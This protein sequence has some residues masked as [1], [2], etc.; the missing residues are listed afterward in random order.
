MKR[1]EV[2]QAELLAPAGLRPVVIPTRDAVLDTLESIVV[3]LVTR[4]I[5]ELPSEVR[6][7]RRE[8]LPRPCVASMDN[9]LPARRSHNQSSVG[10][11]WPTGSR[12]IFAAREEINRQ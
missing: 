11:P 3:A 6:L 12:G 4:T 1:N 2:R 5:R 9:I 10:P 8:G 7:G